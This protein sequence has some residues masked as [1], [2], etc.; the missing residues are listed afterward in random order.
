MFNKDGNSVC[1]PHK[2]PTH[3]FLSSTWRPTLT[4]LPRLFL[5]P[6]TMLRTGGRST[7]YEEGQ[8][9]YPYDNNATS[10]KLGSD[11]SNTV[12]YPLSLSLSLSLSLLG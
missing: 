1:L 5:A 9:E 3:L 2:V 12:K 6:S 8:A 10:F 7:D 4:S 11:T